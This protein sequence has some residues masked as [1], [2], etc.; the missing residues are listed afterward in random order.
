MY[1]DL[2]RFYLT[3]LSNRSSLTCITVLLSLPSPVYLYYLPP[4]PH[5]YICLTHIL[6]ITYISGLL[7]LSL[8]VY[9]AH[10][11]S[12]TYMPYLLFSHLYMSYWRLP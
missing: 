10:L 1:I 3:Y 2:T 11:L 9:Q 8:P 6:Y 4:I 7:S 12:L 5:L